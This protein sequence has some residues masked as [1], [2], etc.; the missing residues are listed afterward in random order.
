MTSTIRCLHWNYCCILPTC[1][2]LR[3]QVHV[4]NMTRLGWG[5]GWTTVPPTKGFQYFPVCC[6]PEL[7]QGAGG[8]HTEMHGWLQS[9][10]GKKVSPCV[11]V[12]TLDSPLAKPYNKST[13]AGR[14]PGVHLDS[15]WSHGKIT[16]ECTEAKPQQCPHHGRW[17]NSGPQYK[18][19]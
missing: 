9:C 11:Y 5:W 17:S 2:K 8:L 1:L 12:D 6:Q 15:C 7:G 16:Q 18:G 3:R 14:E 10:G 4:R 19:A 13:E